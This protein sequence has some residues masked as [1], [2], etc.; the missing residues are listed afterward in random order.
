MKPESPYVIRNDIRFGPLEKLSIPELV[1]ANS[2]RWFNQSLCSVN[3][4]VVRL[5]HPR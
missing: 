4:C 1:A 2:E 5:N 3:D